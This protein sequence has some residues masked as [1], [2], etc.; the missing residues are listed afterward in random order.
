MLQIYCHVDIINK[1]IGASAP[2]ISFLRNSSQL[3]INIQIH[4]DHDLCNLREF[5]HL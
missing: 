4:V 2:A 1:G 3:E 5:L